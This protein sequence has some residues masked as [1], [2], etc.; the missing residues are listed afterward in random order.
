[1]P[2]AEAGVLAGVLAPFP[3]GLL[4]G[5]ALAM[6]V[7]PIGLLC[8]R[9]SL[10]DGFPVGFA[11]G[12]GAAVADAGYGA[13]AAFGLTAVSAFLLSWQAVLG[14]AGG[15]LLLWLGLSSWR[16]APA[17]EAAPAAAAPS[18]LAALAQ[19][20]LLTA[21]NPQTVLTFAALVGGLG[22]GAST[23]AGAGEGGWDRAAALVLGVFL[24]SAAWWLVL[25]GGVA[26]LL[27]GRLGARRIRWINRAAGLLIA[28]FGAAAVARGLGLV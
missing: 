9:R 19:T 1:M 10:Q 16:A 24:G 4:F 18:P 21:G 6:P 25:A 11:T 17:E 13:V 15:A 2:A 23:G 8:I 5:L 27:R 12:L 7:G 26:G 14:V 22:L 20:A 28:G 3:T